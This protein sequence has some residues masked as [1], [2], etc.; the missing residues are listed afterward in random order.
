MSIIVELKSKLVK[1]WR[2]L[3]NDKLDAENRKAAYADI[4]TF[5]DEVSKLDSNF[6][7]SI[8]MLG[9]YKEFKS[10]EVV[11]RVLWPK[12]NDNI[13]LAELEN[14]LDKLTSLAVHITKKRLPR[15]PQDSPM[16]GAIISATVDKLI[17]LE[18]HL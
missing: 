16:F 13:Q 5:S 15:E 14:H 11:P 18:K 12:Y 10:K 6:K 4:I 1:A 3:K 7:M 2:D 8:E 9:K 17:A